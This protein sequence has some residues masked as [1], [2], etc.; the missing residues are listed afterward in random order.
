MF[1]AF[2]LHLAA[3]RLLAGISLRYPKMNLKD[4]AE[5]HLLMTHTPSGV[6]TPGLRVPAARLLNTLRAQAWTPIMET[7]VQIPAGL[8]PMEVSRNSGE[9]LWIIM[10]MVL[11][12]DPSYN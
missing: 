12:V 9:L 2:Y 7:T 3:V 5:R 11:W 4:P 10:I 8:P 1:Y 6:G